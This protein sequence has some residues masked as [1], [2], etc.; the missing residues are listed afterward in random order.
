MKKLLAV[1]IILCA[2]GVS[3]SAAD[4]KFTP[5]GRGKWIYCN[6]NEGIRNR[7]LMN[8]DSDPATSEQVL[9]L[10]RLLENTLI[11]VRK[12]VLLILCRR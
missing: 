8:S 11:A 6:N 2:V 1:I 5:E 7:D 9:I 3:A 4:I 12:K 10:T